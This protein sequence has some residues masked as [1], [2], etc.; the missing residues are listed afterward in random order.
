MT[1]QE[2]RRPGPAAALSIALILCG[3][4]VSMGAEPPPLTE[5]DAERVLEEVNEPGAEV[6]LVNVWATWCAP[7]IEEMPDLLRLRREF[8]EQG[9]RLILVSADFESARK[10]VRERLAGLGVDFETFRRAGKDMEFINAL[11]ERWSGALPASFVYDGE[12]RLRH[13][14]QGRASYDEF[15]KLILD[16]MDGD[17]SRPE[18]ET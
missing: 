14:E 15:R 5:A 9:L 3:S 12:G 1:S 16:V 11:D 2:S 13:F 17:G 8:R 10:Q 6:V 7:C 18:E 4:F